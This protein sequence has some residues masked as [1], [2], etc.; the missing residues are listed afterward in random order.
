[1]SPF[2]EQLNLVGGADFGTALNAAMASINDQLSGITFGTGGVDWN[3]MPVTFGPNGGGFYPLVQL[4]NTLI[5]DLSFKGE[6][7]LLWLDPLLFRE[8]YWG[9]R[10]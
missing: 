1:M 9:T 7:E 4:V 10:G 5:G 8:A 6:L 2:C 3:P